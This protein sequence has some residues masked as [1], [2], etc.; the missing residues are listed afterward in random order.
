MLLSRTCKAIHAWVTPVLYSTVVLTT[1]AEFFAFERALY[2]AEVSFDT[3]RGSPS[4]L[5]FPLGTYVQNLWLGQ[6]RSKHGQHRVT[7]TTGDVVMLGGDSGQGRDIW[8]LT[9]SI[10]SMCPS[11]RNLALVNFPPAVLQLLLLRLPTSLESLSIRLGGRHAQLDVPDLS[12]L[13]SLRSL[14]F[15]HTH[16]G[17]NSLVHM[18]QLPGLRTFTR[19]CDG[20]SESYSYAWPQRHARTYLEDSMSQLMY[21]S[22]A[23]EAFERL[24]I[25]SLVDCDLPLEQR[26]AQLEAL[27]VQYGVSGLPSSE[28]VAVR[29]KDARDEFGDVDGLKTLYDDWVAGLDLCSVGCV[30]YMQEHVSRQCLIVQHWV[31]ISCRDSHIGT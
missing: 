29:A 11:I 8:D 15:L 20:C 5:E 6:T 21:L 12:R 19:L 24:T 26:L 18:L 3:Q 31:L 22:R 17:V 14:T 13:T 10:I 1:K 28:R 27:M 2:S 16:I 30:Q 7:A 4:G 9:M 23:S 25:V